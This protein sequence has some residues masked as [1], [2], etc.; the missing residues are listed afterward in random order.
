MP[1]DSKRGAWGCE[2]D[3]ELIAQN[4]LGCPT[5]FR[6]ILFPAFAAP[7]RELGLCLQ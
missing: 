5:E 3:G 2:R 7:R 1:A 4:H 6:Q